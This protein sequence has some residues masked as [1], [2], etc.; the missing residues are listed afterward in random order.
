MKADLHEVSDYAFAELTSTARADIPLPDPPSGDKIL[1]LIKDIVDAAA[2]AAKEP[3]R[4]RTFVQS[5]KFRLHN[6]Y[7]DYNVALCD[8]AQRCSLTAFGKFPDPLQ[9]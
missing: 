7:P 3:A 6:S 5:I 9:R 4:R 1:D 8:M 2:D